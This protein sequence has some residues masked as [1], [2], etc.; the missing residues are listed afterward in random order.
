M[1]LFFFLTMKKKANIGMNTIT[2]GLIAFISFVLV[3]ILGLLLLS[4]IK[5]TNLGCS[6]PTG[7]QSVRY[8][9]G[10]CQACPYAVGVTS[11]VFNTTADYCCNATGGTGN[12]LGTNATGVLAFK[13]NMTSTVTYLTDAAVLPP[14]FASLLMIVIVMVGILALLTVI[15]ITAYRKMQG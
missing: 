13:S 3:A 7:A 5:S 14:Q 10:M 8:K 15:G 4:S 9:D 6:D 2:A 11:Y 12:C 1:P